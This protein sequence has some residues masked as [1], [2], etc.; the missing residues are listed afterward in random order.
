MAPHRRSLNGAIVTV[1]SSIE[2]N[3]QKLVTCMNDRIQLLRRPRPYPDESLPAYNLRLCDQNGYERLSYLL[4]YLK[5]S[6][7]RTVG[8]S[9]GTYNPEH[10]TDLYKLSMITGVELADIKSIQL[11]AAEISDGEIKTKR[12]QIFNQIIPYF[13]FNNRSAKVC[14]MCLRDIPYIRR[15][16]SIVAVTACPYHGSL[17]LDHCPECGKKIA[18]NR[19][20]VSECSCDYDWRSFDAKT[21]DY[22]ETMLSKRIFELC[23]FLKDSSEREINPETNPLLNLDLEHLLSCVFL[24][25]EQ[26]G[27][28][29]SRSSLF[30]RF[31]N[32]GLH[33]ILVAAYRVFE[34]WPIRYYQFLDEVQKRDHDVKADV[35]VKKNFGN[36][37]YSL[38]RNL[39]ESN[40]DFM[41]IAFEDYLSEKWNGGY[42]FPYAYSSRAGLKAK[43]LT[44]QETAKMLGIRQRTAIALVKKNI[45]Q[46]VVRKMG[47]KEMRLI[48]KPGTEELK[49]R[50]DAA[51]TMDESA[52]TLGIKRN[53]VIELVHQ[54]LLE[55]LR[56]PSIE[57]GKIW[58]FESDAL[59]KL[60]QVVRK[61]C[62]S[63]SNDSMRK[64]SFASAV[65]H[66]RISTPVLIKALLNLEIK[67]CWANNKEG[68]AAFLF[69]EEDLQQYR[70]KKSNHASDDVSKPQT[71]SVP[72]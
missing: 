47:T 63:C 12:F 32:E 9:H 14:P 8:Y 72:G 28:V 39:N 38:Y 51:I 20:R 42:L 66:L 53:H 43:Y 55:P 4:N 26:L 61:S 10:T 56:G 25:S 1:D 18:W 2:S 34:D 17:L 64:I 71:S 41:R 62:V 33:K 22:S 57:G 24:I 6:E 29:R 27:L 5:K 16:W 60:V 58:L 52:R 59:T 45:L 19:N 50:Y 3:E 31:N 13:Y 65:L 48:S 67:S 54:K 49:R 30:A 69:S 37:Y 23:G 44:T 35:G 68:F 46:G 21:I 40:Y 11:K 15:I 36:Y 70:M 7:V